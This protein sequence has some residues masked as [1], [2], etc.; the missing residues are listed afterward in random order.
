MD[1][2]GLER[3]EL[4]RMSWGPEVKMIYWLIIYY[5][6]DSF[7]LRLKEIKNFEPQKNINHSHKKVSLPSNSE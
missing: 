1:I 6:F 7:S 3:R 5:L 2:R 4:N